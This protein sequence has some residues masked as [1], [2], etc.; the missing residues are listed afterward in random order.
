M[1]L[2]CANGL[3][4]SVM[5]NAVRGVGSERVRLIGESERVAIPHEDVKQGLFE[6]LATGARGDP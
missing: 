5:A 2:P 3:G 6:W 4:Q 1:R